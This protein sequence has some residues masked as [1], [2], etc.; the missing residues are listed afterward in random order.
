MSKIDQR[1]DDFTIPEVVT[2][3]LKRP[4]KKDGAQ[5]TELNFRPPSVRELREARKIRNTQDPMASTTTLLSLI[6]IEKL[7]PPEIEQL[8]VLDYALVEEAIS[9]FLVLSDP[10]AED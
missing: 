8:A 10:S 7:A 5:L 2:V 1:S 4:I 3:K 9:P 6:S